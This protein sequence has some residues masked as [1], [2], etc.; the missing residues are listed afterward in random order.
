MKL[1]LRTFFGN[2]GNQIFTMKFSNDSKM[3]AAGT[4]DGDIKI[5]DVMEGKNITMARSWM[6]TEAPTTSVRW[7]PKKGDIDSNFLV[8]TNA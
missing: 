2:Q 3:I 5:Y 4:I 6:K 8:A 1:K 7:R